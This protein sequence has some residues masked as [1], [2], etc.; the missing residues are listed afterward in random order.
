MVQTLATV[1]LRSEP[2]AQLCPS[3]HK[4]HGVVASAPDFSDSS[5]V[6][7]AVLSPA[8]DADPD[9]IAYLSVSLLPPRD[10]GSPLPPKPAHCAAYSGRRSPALCPPECSRT[11]LVCFLWVLKN[12]DA[13]LPGRW[14]V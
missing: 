10:C 7:S 5:P 6:G 3:S 1:N 9:S 8:D 14:S 13:A 12:A 2:V 11:L 4:S